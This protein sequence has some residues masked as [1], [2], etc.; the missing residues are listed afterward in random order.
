MNVINHDNKLPSMESLKKNSLKVLNYS[1]SAWLD[2]PTFNTFLYIHKWNLSVIWCM[3]EENY[4]SFVIN[5]TG[6]ISKALK[7]L[8][9]I[10]I[11]CF[12]KIWW[13]SPVK[14]FQLGFNDQ[15]S[16]INQ[17]KHKYT[18]NKQC[19]LAETT[20]PGL[21][22]SFRPCWFQVLKCLAAPH[23]SSLLSPAFFC[24][25]FILR[26]TYFMW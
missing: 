6:K 13:I 24:D 16:N 2:F 12:F 15:K 8:N 26:Q 22:I 1:Y 5:W 4:R 18:N 9:S 20:S 25:Y 3:F 10:E 17:I 14:S 23:H 11:I 7:C 19:W 21:H